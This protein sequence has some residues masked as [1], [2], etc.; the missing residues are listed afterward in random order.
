MLLLIL[1]R[2]LLGKCRLQHHLEKIKNNLSHQ[3]TISRILQP[4]PWRWSDMIEVF[5]ISQK[6]KKSKGLRDVCL[7]CLKLFVRYRKCYILDTNCLLHWR[8][9][10]RERTDKRGSWS[11]TCK[12]ETGTSLSFPKDYGDATILCIFFLISQKK[13]KRNATECIVDKT[14]L[15]L[16]MYLLITAMT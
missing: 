7:Y 13:I 5:V 10:K 14:S 16:A 4:F 12:N 15:A 9:K 8:S 2:L 3:W 1:I 6:D 11:C